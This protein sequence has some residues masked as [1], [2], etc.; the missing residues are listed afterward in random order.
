MQEVLRQLVQG[1]LA[2]HQL[3]HTLN[4]WALEKDFGAL[5]RRSLDVPAEEQ[6][7]W[8]GCIVLQ[9]ERLCVVH[10]VSGW[11]E[12]VN[13]KCELDDPEHDHYVGFAHTHL[14]DVVSG[15]P[16][17]GF[18]ERDFRATLAD[19]DRLSLVCNGPEVFAL[20]RTLDR[21]QPPRVPDDTEFASWKR[22]YDDAI[23]QTDA[24]WCLTQPCAAGAAMRLTV[25]SGR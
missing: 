3:P 10:P 12:G 15:R 24:P 6:V 1:Q 17:L 8:G 5:R 16:Y 4:V 7:E 19:G 9:A 14:S 11:K 2:S 20:V 23:K 18:S 22:L 21:T 13:P 25:P